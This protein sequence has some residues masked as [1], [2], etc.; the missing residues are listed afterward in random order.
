MLAG[1]LSERLRDS[2]RW[3]KRCRFD[4]ERQSVGSRDNLVDA[5]HHAWHKVHDAEE[6]GMKK[7]IGISGQPEGLHELE[8]GDEILLTQAHC[9]ND[10]TITGRASEHWTTLRPCGTSRL[11]T[12]QK[13]R[14]AQAARDLLACTDQ[15]RCLHPPGGPW[16]R[17]Q[18][19]GRHTSPRSGAGEEIRTPDL[20]STREVSG[21]SLCPGQRPPVPGCP[22]HPANSRSA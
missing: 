15:S 20:R 9:R 19:G 6:H 22:R 11:D 10:T 18:V 14:R 16:R 13:D 2:V 5:G 12:L 7:L 21:I 1:S 4:P 8:Y 3:P 17:P